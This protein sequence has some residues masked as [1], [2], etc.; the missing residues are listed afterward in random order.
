MAPCGCGGGSTEP[1]DYEAR[2]SDGSTIR[3]R[4]E[5][6]ARAAVTRAGGGQ[7]KPVPRGALVG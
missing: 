1:M 4:T 2:F 3:Y 7:V 6:E 5:V